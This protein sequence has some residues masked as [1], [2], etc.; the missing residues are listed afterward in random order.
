[1]RLGPRIICSDVGDAA[2]VVVNGRTGI[3]AST[4]VDWG[5]AILALSS[6]S[7]L[8]ER[9]GAAGRK[10]AEQEYSFQACAPRVASILQNLI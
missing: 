9:L 6:N 1:M 8:R 5:Q 2:R 7:E 10:R 4:P 3:V